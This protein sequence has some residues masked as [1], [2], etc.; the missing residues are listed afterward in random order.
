MNRF[1]GSNFEYN[2]SEGNPVLIYNLQVVLSGN[3]KIDLKSINR[4]KLTAK[5]KSRFAFVNPRFQK[6]DQSLSI[7]SEGNI[8]NSN[9]PATSNHI[10]T[11]TFYLED[12][13]DRRKKSWVDFRDHYSPVLDGVR[14]GI[15][16]GNSPERVSLY[17]VGIERV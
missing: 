16:N 4:M 7:T 5:L 13:L 1:N 15:R 14:E 3:S 11:G 8:R 10:H 2:E 12:N 17:M 6:L 9:L